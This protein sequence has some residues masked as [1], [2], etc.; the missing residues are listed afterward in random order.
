[1]ASLL[2]DAT[3]RLFSEGLGENAMRQA[4]AG[5]WLGTGWAGV[6]RLGL[7]YAMLP[8]AKGGLGLST[9][10]A[11]ELIKL[12]GRHAS[13]LPIAETIIANQALS[14]AGLAPAIGPA[15]IVPDGVTIE[16][17]GS[18]WRLAGTA[19]RVPW[20][21]NVTTLVVEVDGYVARLTTGWSVASQGGNV[22]GMP[23]DTLTIDAI[24]GA[25]DVAALQ[26]PGLLLGGATIRALQMAGAVAR[27]LD[28]TVDHINDRIRFGRT[29]ARFQAMQDELALVAGQ[30]AAANAAADMAAEAWAVQPLAQ[31][32]PIAGAR[33][34]IGDAAREALNVCQR[35]HGEAGFSADSRLSLYT[36]ALLGWR[37]EYGGDVFWSRI[38]GHAAIAAA[39][40]G[41]WSFLAAA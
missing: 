31:P 32:L 4:R 41:Y 5:D 36:T 19:I 24:L 13:P 17:D 20:G 10:E 38:L 40:E 39:P 18:D 12:S 15:A 3:L 14:A 27:V 11:F 9:Q 7:P 1:M 2:F 16:R 22:A 26:G 35:L 30:V 29:L 34:R 8:V 23:R 28:L 6:E 25:A 21:R 37:D 33:V